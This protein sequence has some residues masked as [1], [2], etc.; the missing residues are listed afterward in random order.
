MFNI[1]AEAGSGVIIAID[2]TGGDE[3]Q[4]RFLETQREHVLRGELPW[5]AGKGRFSSARCSDTN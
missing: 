3:M 4:L 2:G 1:D 5:V